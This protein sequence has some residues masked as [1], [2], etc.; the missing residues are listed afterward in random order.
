MAAI[1][2]MKKTLYMEKAENIDQLIE[3][4]ADEL[5]MA[6]HVYYD[7]DSLQYGVMFE[8]WLSEY[9]DFLDLTDEAFN[10][11]PEDELGG[12]QRDEVADLRKVVELPHCID[13]PL[14]S[15]SFR[16]MEEFIGLHANNRKF[17][18]DAVKALRNRHPFRG[19]RAALDY[20]GLTDAWYPFRD[21]K[22]EA[23]VR[24]EIARHISQNSEH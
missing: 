3:K 4:I 15:E 21:A 18:G 14:S 1:P 9:G 8:D 5:T 12:W 10:E 22:M 23:Y 11:I 17:V 19:F 13:K 16:W 20:N 6:D 2:I 7:V 24:N